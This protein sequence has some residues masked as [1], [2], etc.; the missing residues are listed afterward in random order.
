MR[1]RVKTITEVTHEHGVVSLD[2]PLYETLLEHVGHESVTDK[3][4]D[5]LIEKTIK[6]TEEEEGDAL[7]HEHLPALTAGQPMTPALAEVTSS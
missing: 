3:H 4:I 1:K 2:I 7:T 5:M 6:I